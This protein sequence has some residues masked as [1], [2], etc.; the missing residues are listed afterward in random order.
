[1]NTANIEA[2]V[3]INGMT[4]ASCVNRIESQ[5][6]KVEGVIDVNVSLATETAKLTLRDNTS[7]K[8][9]LSAIE[10]SGYEV[11]TKEKEFAVEGMTCASCVNRIESVLLKEQGVISAS[12]NLATEKAKIKYVDGLL[13][14]EDLIRIIAKAGYKASRPKT[15]INEE[16][17]EKEK[18]LKKEFFKLLIATLL[19]APLVLPM[20]FEPFGYDFMLK[21]WPQLILATPV[22]FWLGARFYKAAWKAV[23]ARSG[24]MDLLVSLGTSAAYGL[25]LYHLFLYGEHAG[26]EGLGPLY[27]ESSAVVIT[28]VLLGKYLESKAKQQTSAAIKA[29]QSLRP[30]IARVK[31]GINNEV[32][33]SIDDLNLGDIVVVRPGEKIPVDGI[34]IA[35]STQVDESFITG[36]SLPVVKNIKDAVTGGSV[37]VDGLIEIETSALGAETTL[38]RII[39]LVE[40]AQSAKA[41]IQRLVDKVS[42]V[43]V[44]IVIVIALLTILGWGLYSGNWEQA[45]IN[46]VAVLVIACPCALGL[47][48]PT[49]IMVGTGLAAKVGILIKD[50]EAL[51]VAHSVTVVAFDKTGTLTVGKPELAKILTHEK[52]EYE[53]VRI[54]SSIQSG[55]EH[56]LAK[57]VIEKAAMM[58]LAFDPSNDVKALAGR[59]LEGT[60]D[61]DKHI[62][63]TKR[64]MQEKSIDVSIFTDAATLYELDGHTVSY[65]ANEKQNKVIGLLAFSDQIKGTARETIRQLN[66]LNIRTVMIT[67]DNSGAAKKVANAL[68]ISEFRAEVL[69]QDKS[70]II[71]ELKS[72]GEIVAMVGDGI[73]DAP[74][75]AAA[76]VGI[77]MSTGTDVAMH[78]AGIT[79]MRGNPLLIPDALEISRRTYQKIKQ[80]L[81]WAFI[82]NIVGIP[83][84]AFGLLSPVIAGAAMAFSSVS[85]VTNALMLRNWKPK[86]K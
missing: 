76:H 1:M 22:Q 25:S 86:S 62:I 59:G 4:C 17:D 15:N 36:E 57:A 61:G 21:G 68:N 58:N 28:L 6:K 70:K 45:L 69:P 65:V 73:N 64:L 50:A 2:N 7:I 37:N 24:N 30:D 34:I 27:F 38:A 12:V 26:H 23:K 46:G 63:G 82:Y 47:A 77:A 85:V 78:T 54:A 41:P 14:E 51:E 13:N 56:P 18:L 9:S 60:V 20:I 3:K 8:A 79:L 35:G 29:L 40:N 71:E 16:V 81:F 75:L 48:T 5:V 43:F 11:A 80:N 67:G 10:K 31:R 42:A 44:P 84:A 83:L 72:T 33:M 55:S 66:A 19:S 52:S 74:A 49:S 53:L 39:R 32:E